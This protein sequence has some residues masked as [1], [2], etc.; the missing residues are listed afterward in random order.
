MY[1]G[2]KECPCVAQWEEKCPTANDRGN[3]LASKRDKNSTGKV[4]EKNVLLSMAS[5]RK[6]APAL[7]VIRRKNVVMVDGRS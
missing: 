2:R 6:Y 3:A 4:G 5:G 7:L 1:S